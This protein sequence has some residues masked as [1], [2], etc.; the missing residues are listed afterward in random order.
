MTVLFA[1]LRV[2]GYVAVIL[3]S[4]AVLGISAYFASIFLP[5]L[6][7]DFSIYSLI[8]PSWTIFMFTL[9]LISSTPYT[10]AIILF[11]SGILWLTLAAWSSDS[12]GSTQCDALGNSRTSTK[13]GTISARSYCDL[14]KVIEAFSWATF[15]LSTFFSPISTFPHP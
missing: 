6:H 10:D 3:T 1:N 12:L 13:N 7:H 4:A 15:S 5:H 8:P 2:Y 9:I 14:S 11:I